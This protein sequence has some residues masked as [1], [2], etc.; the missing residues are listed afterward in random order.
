[1][2]G[3]VWTQLIADTIA[4]GIALYFFRRVLK[5][6]NQERSEIR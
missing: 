5:Q 1:M 2:T 3:A 6:L 4:V